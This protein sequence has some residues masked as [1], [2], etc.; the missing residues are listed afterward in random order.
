M[1]KK[2]F[3]KKV[4]ELAN[5]SEKTTEL[6]LKGFTEALTQLMV[7]G[8]KIALPDLGTF[9][10]VAKPE[11]TGINPATKEKIIIAARNSIKFKPAKALKEAV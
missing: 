8:D 3:V 7:Q 10:V 9:E 5:Q 1:N 11:R 6:V 2:D 4:A